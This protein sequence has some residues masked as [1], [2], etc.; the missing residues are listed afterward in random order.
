M[1]L[2]KSEIEHVHKVLSLMLNNLECPI[3][4]ELMKEPV[5]TKCDHQFCRFCILK[6]FGKTK[7]SILCPLCKNKLTK[8]S[9]QESTRF[10][11]LAEGI[12]KTIRAFELDTG[13]E[14]SIDDS[15]KTRPAEIN[16]YKQL[17]KDDSSAQSNN[18]PQTILAAGV[19]KSR[20]LN[21]CTGRPLTDVVRRVSTRNKKQKIDAEPVYVEIDSD[22]SEESLFRVHIKERLT[23]QQNT[24]NKKATL[25]EEKS[26][27]CDNDEKYIEE[28]KSE[29]SKPVLE[30]LSSEMDDNEVSEETANTDAGDYS[31]ATESEAGIKQMTGNKSES[32]FCSPE[33]PR[34]LLGSPVDKVNEKI[35]KHAIKMVNPESRSDGKE[36]FTDSLVPLSSENNVLKKDLE[37]LDNQ[38]QKDSNWIGGDKIDFHLNGNDSNNSSVLK[39]SKRKSQR[40]LKKV[41]E[42]LS[43]INVDEVARLGVD[44]NPCDQNTDSDSLAEKE[45]CLASCEEASSSA[46]TEKVE[47]DHLASPLKKDKEVTKALAIDIKNKVFGKTYKRDKRKSAPINWNF[48]SAG[49]SDD[50]L[51]DKEPVHEISSNKTQKGKTRS[52]GLHPEDFIKTSINDEGYPVGVWNSNTKIDQ[53]HVL[54]PQD[55]EIEAHE[56][57]IEKSSDSI[58]EGK[59]IAPIPK[60]AVCD[61]TVETE[62]LE[63]VCKQNQ[64]Q[65]DLELGKTDA[66]DKKNTNKVLGKKGKKLSTKQAKKRT[67]P[68]QL[69]NQLARASP[70]SSHTDMNENKIDSF[71]SS[72]G[73]VKT[74]PEVRTTRR[75][76][77]LKL[78]DE[79]IVMEGKKTPEPTR[80][81]SP[82]GTGVDIAPSVQNVE[83]IDTGMVCAETESLTMEDIIAQDCNEQ[84]S[85]ANCSNEN[86]TSCGKCVVE[87]LEDGAAHGL[88]GDKE[89]QSRDCNKTEETGNAALL[90]EHP[91]SRDHSPFPIASQDSGSETSVLLLAAQL[92]PEREHGAQ[93][94]RSSCAEVGKLSSNDTTF[95][96]ENNSRIAAMSN[97]ENS[98][99]EMTAKLT[100]AKEITG[101]S[102]VDTEQ[103]L[104][105]FKRA[106]R[107]SFILLPT[108]SCQSV[109]DGCRGSPTSQTQSGKSKDTIKRAVINRKDDRNFISRR[110]TGKLNLDKTTGIKETRVSNEV[111]AK[112]CSSE[113]NNGLQQLNRA[114]RDSVEIVPPTASLPLPPVL[115]EHGQ[116]MVPLSNRTKGKRKNRQLRKKGSKCSTLVTT[117]KEE[118]DSDRSSQTGEL[119]NRNTNNNSRLKA[120]NLVKDTVVNQEVQQ[121]VLDLELE[122]N[123]HSAIECFSAGEIEE[124]VEIEKDIYHERESDKLLKTR[125]F[126]EN[127]E[128]HEVP[129]NVEGTTDCKLVKLADSPFMHSD[130]NKSNIAGNKVGENLQM[131]FATSDELFDSAKPS[132]QKNIAVNELDKLQSECDVR[133]DQVQFKLYDE[134]A[135]LN[136]SLQ[137]SSQ[138]R[139]R[140][141]KKRPVKLST[142]ESETSDDDLPCFQLF[143]F[144]KL[145][146]KTQ[147]VSQSPLSTTCLSLKTSQVQN[148]SL[149]NH[150]T[151]IRKT[152]F[153]EVNK[154]DESKG[155]DCPQNIS[156]SPSQE[157]EESP[158]LFSSSDGSSPNPSPQPKVSHKTLRKQK[159]AL[160]LSALEI[161]EEKIEE[162][163]KGSSASYLQPQ[164]LEGRTV[165]HYDSDA[166]HTGDSFSPECEFLTTQQKHAMQ[167][168]IKK[169]ER[170]MA[171][172]EAVLDQ[173]GSHD[174]EHL[175]SLNHQE[176]CPK[177]LQHQEK[178]N[179]SL[180][181]KVTAA[182]PL[183]DAEILQTKSKCLP[184]TEGLGPQ[185][186]LNTSITFTHVNKEETECP[187]P[188]MDLEIGQIPENFQDA[189]SLLH[190]FQS[191][192]VSKS[193]QEEMKE[194][195]SAKRIKGKKEQANLENEGNAMLLQDI[196][197]IPKLGSQGKKECDLVP[198]ERTSIQSPRMA[199]QHKQGTTG[200]LSLPQSQ[201]E[202]A[203]S[204]PISESFKQ[205][206]PSRASSPVFNKISNTTSNLSIF[207][208]KMSFVASG[209]NRRESQLIEAFTKKMGAEFLSN[210]SP[211]TTH[212]IM[213]TDA[214]FVCERTLKYFMG[215]A[216]RRW[217]VSYQWII[218][219]FREGSIVDE[220]EFE[221]RGDV[222]N[223]RNH[224]GPRKARKTADAELLLSQYEICC[225]GSFTGMSRDQLEWM[226]ELCGASIVKEPC[227]FTYSPNCTEVVVVQPDA[228]PINTDY[229]AIQRQYNSIVVSREWILD[230][231]ACYENHQL[232]AYL[233]CL[234]D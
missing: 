217:V 229:R 26:D 135:E 42:W 221:V 89:R 38:N 114:D 179:R 204:Q 164:R 106:K 154:L 77:R 102:E 222:I 76:S 158:D 72:A 152:V 21:D 117:E 35:V 91:L 24:V 93:N 100:G 48:R 184:A 174:A 58:Q 116:Q 49:K 78:L 54:V 144:N 193:R 15:Q 13:Y 103:L 190:Q 141:C 88:S 11:Q 79:K 110:K 14:F 169:L 96:S 207:H 121:N 98:G 45:S 52:N 62:Y 31:C 180:I 155:K 59:P 71:P 151:E 127:S 20:T 203:N 213:K 123:V 230:S 32:S 178:T 149:P 226:I 73:T 172:L 210:F 192:A 22:S 148:T 68:L 175:L 133:D 40:I 36:L 185:P 224:N 109:G 225:Y 28:N 18:T 130:A 39:V 143:G 105:S 12:V 206:S 119:L 57:M 182:F 176:D 194:P 70:R 131:T 120:A 201:E 136:S 56:E 209:L 94:V 34:E 83:N 139:A 215:I 50:L 99:E 84:L 212:V 199:L 80:L 140:G 145:S 8:R 74:E 37:M 16:S 189:N 118:F 104:K 156:L 124:V 162:T 200:S 183:G 150:N 111:K 1:A 44:S 75:S 4:L 196:T 223:G 197:L 27:Q 7:G 161:Q 2:C 137:N 208:R 211:S 167:N 234:P 147:S 97:E 5:S 65:P 95:I 227:L 228:N 171:V 64:Q 132:F 125:E 181:E 9:L 30:E 92:V 231:I 81:H 202:K 6:L 122:S 220:L 60:E 159:K 66:E 138:G 25:E 41:S 186:Q 153:T 177:S 232:K 233:I 53:E 112:Q 146:S 198:A 188:L 115:P 214:D 165:P 46:E 67:K 134:I 166:S 205:N 47:Y 90:A 128:L 33:A 218:E 191:E 108:T 160:N 85:N 168:N 17:W 126:Y 29:V 129:D 187:K 163:R 10:K 219:C 157:S 113:L 63:E 142:S 170:E 87:E 107:K 51:S 69:V 55:T 195:S 101:D 173:H 82:L 23:L 43:K 19:S 86:L 61:E 3:C 216:G